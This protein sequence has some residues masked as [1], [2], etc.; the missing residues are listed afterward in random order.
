MFFGGVSASALTETEFSEYIKTY[1]LQE[2]RGH[3][4]RMPPCRSPTE[5][6]QKSPLAFQDWM[7]YAKPIFAYSSNL[8]NKSL[9]ALAKFAG[10]REHRVK[11]VS[12]RPCV[13][14]TP[15]QPQHNL[16]RIN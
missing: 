3:A 9:S 15:V 2:L 16:L 11:V 13:T 12:S 1:L 14:S 8:P 4:R 10:N 7:L 6:L 5:S